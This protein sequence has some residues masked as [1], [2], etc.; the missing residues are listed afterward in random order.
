MGGRFTWI[1]AVRHDYPAI[2]APAG[3]IVISS[4]N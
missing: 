2:V 4:A 1:N 3:G